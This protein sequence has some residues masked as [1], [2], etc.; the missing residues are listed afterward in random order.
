M[1][2]LCVEECIVTRAILE[3]F[4]RNL[5]SKIW[6]S[7]VFSAKT[8]TCLWAFVEAKSSIC[9]VVWPVS[10]TVHQFEGNKWNKAGCIYRQFLIH[11]SKIGK[12]P[13][14][15]LADSNSM[16]PAN[17]IFYTVPSVKSSVPKVVM[18]DYIMNGERLELLQQQLRMCLRPTLS[19]MLQWSYKRSGFLAIAIARA[20]PANCLR[21]EE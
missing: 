21:H 11:R 17:R 2:V 5:D 20:V 4:D 18:S 3:H 19:P 12:Q 15:A 1:Q 13:K 8:N 10:I 9:H 6:Y 16:F 7:Q 14:S